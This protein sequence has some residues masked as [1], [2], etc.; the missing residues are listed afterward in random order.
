MSAELHIK[1][2]YYFEVPKFMWR[3]HNQAKADFPEV[4]VKNDPQFQKAGEAERELSE[5]EKL[6]SQFSIQVC[7]PLG[8]LEHLLTEY[9]G[10]V[11]HDHANFGKPFHVYLEEGRDGLHRERVR[12]SSSKANVAAQK[13]I[14]RLSSSLKTG[15]RCPNNRQGRLRGMPKFPRILHFGQKWS[16]A[17]SRGKPGNVSRIWP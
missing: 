9:E 17:K 3:Y 8:V 6:Q 4:W 7:L 1:D 2:S 5:L 11:E 14:T 10:W 13:R 16:Q 15:W 12:R